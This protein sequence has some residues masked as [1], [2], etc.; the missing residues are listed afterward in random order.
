MKGLPYD[1][2]VPYIAKQVGEKCPSVRVAIGRLVKKGLVKPTKRGFYVCTGA[3]V[4]NGAVV[5]AEIGLHGIKLEYRKSRVEGGVTSKQ[6]S[7]VTKGANWVTEWVQGDIIAG[8]HRHPINGSITE[9]Y[10]WAGRVI[11]ITTYAKTRAG[12]EVVELWLQ[13]SERDLRNGEFM[14]FISW[15]QGRYPYVPLALWRVRQ[16]GINWDVRGLH[17]DG[18]DKMTLQIFQNMW[19][20]LYNHARFVR[21]ETHMTQNIGLDQAVQVFSRF[22]EQFAQQT[23]AGLVTP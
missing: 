16:V 20:T 13:A 15:V 17:L 12:E 8:T 3:L 6:A 5:L 22:V 9:S 14:E 2:N 21:V 23:G 4:E 1:A 18:V 19:L 7:D 10:E 11:T